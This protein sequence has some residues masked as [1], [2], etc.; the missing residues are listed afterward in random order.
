MEQILLTTQN[1]KKVQAKQAQYDTLLL[2][3]NGRAQRLTTQIG[4]AIKIAEMSSNYDRY[5]AL[6]KELDEVT[7][8]IKAVEQEMRTPDVVAVDNNDDND[9][10]VEVLSVGESSVS[11]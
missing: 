2:S 6:N 4:F 1:N 11:D 5:H 8:E 10:A 9:N 7:D 3:L